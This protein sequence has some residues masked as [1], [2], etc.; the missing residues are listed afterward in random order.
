MTR[1]DLQPPPTQ[2]ARTPPGSAHLVTLPTPPCRRTGGRPGYPAGGG[3]A[4]LPGRH[5][6]PP[7][8]PARHHQAPASGAPGLRA[9]RSGG[10]LPGAG[11]PGRLYGALQ[12]PPRP[13]GPPHTG[14]EEG[15]AGD[16]HHPV[17]PPHAVGR[18]RAGG[19]HQAFPSYSPGQLWAR[20]TS[21]WQSAV[22][23]AVVDQAIYGNVLFT[24]ATTCL[25]P[26]WT[27]LYLALQDMLTLVT[28][29]AEAGHR[30]GTRVR[31]DRPPALHRP[32]PLAAPLQEAADRVLQKVPGTA[33]APA[34]VGPATEESTRAPPQ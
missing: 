33:A 23:F 16:L 4:A 29:Q 12:H 5:L 32:H 7:H 34:G 31:A 24:L 6:P 11:R 22:V 15:G 28:L 17:P 26:V 2:P 14:T 3:G 25:L 9:H 21:A 27:L 13:P 8:P 19:H 30:R 18:R 1:T 10:V 20:T